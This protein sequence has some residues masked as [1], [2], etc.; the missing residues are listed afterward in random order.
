MELNN[1]IKVVI[2]DFDGTI[3]KIES[4]WRGWQEG[5]LKIFHKYEPSFQT[6]DIKYIYKYLNVFFEKYKNTNLHQEVVDFSDHWELDH[7]DKVTSNNLVVE[8]IKRL[9]MEGIKI[10]VWSNNGEEFL[11]RELGKLEIADSISII[12]GRNSS[13]YLKP[14]AEAFEKIIYD[15]GLPRSEYLMIGNEDDSDGVAAKAAGIRYV[16]VNELFK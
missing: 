14:S 4:D 1:N 10:F 6:D 8:Y 11:K 5:I 12:C 9:F 7:C 16:N 2:F 15:P 3:A 13:Y